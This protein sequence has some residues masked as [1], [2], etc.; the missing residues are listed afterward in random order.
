[1][2]TETNEVPAWDAGQI[3]LLC[4]QASG[5]GVHC[6]PSADILS[7]LDELEQARAAERA[8]NAE[9]SLASEQLA[10]CATELERIRQERDFLRLEILGRLRLC[11][12]NDAAN[13]S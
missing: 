9:L 6:M 4:A 1:M 10:A 12:V 13:Q 2:S 3:A 5:Y 7:L 8:K 11:Y